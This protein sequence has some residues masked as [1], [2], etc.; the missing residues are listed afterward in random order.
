MAAL[1]ATVDGGFF[2][3]RNAAGEIAISLASAENGGYLSVWNKAGEISVQVDAGGHG[4]GVV[5]AG[6]FKSKGRTLQPGP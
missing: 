5:E 6:D 3:V 2:S 1:E 4:N